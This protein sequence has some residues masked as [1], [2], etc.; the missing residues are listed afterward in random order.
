[1]IPLVTNVYAFSKAQEEHIRIE[2]IIEEIS[3]ED[4]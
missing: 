2:I 3:K 1:M 4:H